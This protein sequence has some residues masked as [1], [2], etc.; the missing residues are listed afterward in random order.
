MFLEADHE[1]ALLGRQLPVD[2]AD[3]VAVAVFPHQHVVL[4]GLSDALWRGISG[5]AEP[6]PTGEVGQRPEA[7]CDAQYR[8]LARSGEGP[9]GEREWV[10]GRAQE[11][12]HPGSARVGWSQ[13]CTRRTAA[14]DRSR[15]R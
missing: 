10:G 11:R 15:G 4:T 3:V 1:V 6:H 13:R 2:P 7:W 5:G 14:S 8:R 12:T 9:G